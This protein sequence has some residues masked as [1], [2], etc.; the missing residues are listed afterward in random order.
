MIKVIQATSL[1]SPRGR[2]TE[3]KIETGS[4]CSTKE[5]GNIIRLRALARIESLIEA[6]QNLHLSSEAHT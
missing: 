1:A 6:D 4:R 5:E 2:G 3:C